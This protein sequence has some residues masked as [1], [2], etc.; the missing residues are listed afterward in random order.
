MSL[1]AKDVISNGSVTFLLGGLISF[2]LLSGQRFK[3]GGSA[4][5]SLSLVSIRS[6]RT[7]RIIHIDIFIIYIYIDFFYIK[8][9][10]P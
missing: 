8:L 3:R 7:A 1:S 10:V 2:V 4:S 9:K 6:S 5:F